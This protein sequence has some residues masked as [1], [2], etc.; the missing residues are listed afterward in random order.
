MITLDRNIQFQA[1]LPLCCPTPI[2][3]TLEFDVPTFPPGVFTVTQTGPYNGQ[4]NSIPIQV[5]IDEEATGPGDFIVGIRV[6]GCGS[7]TYATM[8][9][10]ISGEPPCGATITID[11]SGEGVIQIPYPIGGFQQGIL[12]SKT[13]T[14]LGYEECCGTPLQTI[15]LVP[16]DYFA[17][18]YTVDSTSPYT[19]TVDILVTNAPLLNALLVTQDLDLLLSLDFTFGS[20]GCSTQTG[21]VVN[22][23][24]EQA[25]APAVPCLPEFTVVPYNNN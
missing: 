14:L 24:V 7:D 11:T 4:T 1:P 20:E 25:P 15:I 9:V 3:L 23:N 19:V 17:F 8:T 21:V 22:Y 12:T 16:T 6:T 10:V 18:N 5:V 13:F 2:T